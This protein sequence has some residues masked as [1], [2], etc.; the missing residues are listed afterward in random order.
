MAETRGERV[1]CW[2]DH[3]DQLCDDGETVERRVDL[4]DA[5]VVVTNRRVMTFTPESDGPHFRHIDRPNVGAVSVETTERLSQLVWGIAAAVV[6]VGLVETARAIRFTEYVPG[7]ELQAVGSLP[8]ANAIENLVNGALSAI[9]TALLILD[10]AIL[11]SGGVAFAVATAFVVRYVRSRSYR[12]VL[13]I[14]GHDDL[15][16][17]VGDADLE[18][19][20]VT[21]LE[22]AI[23]PGSTLGGSSPADGH[24]GVDDG[25]TRLGSDR[26]G[27]DRDQNDR[28]GAEWLGDEES[29]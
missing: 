16:L 29:G 26:R 23:R 21:D 1:D 12:L 14:R 4:E 22:A 3:V 5:T 6:G 11:L 20:L 19:D 28:P 27:D 24:A 8:G 10:W 13:R 2:T 25:D 17:P 9:E 7:F 15:V 18:A